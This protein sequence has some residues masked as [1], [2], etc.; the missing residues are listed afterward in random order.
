[1]C[2]TIDERKL[3][4]E[5]IAPQALTFKPENSIRDQHDTYTIYVSYCEA[6]IHSEQVNAFLKLAEQSFCT[7]KAIALLYIKTLATHKTTEL[8]VQSAYRF[9][10]LQQSTHRGLREIQELIIQWHLELQ[11]EDRAT[12]M[13]L[14]ILLQYKT[15]DDYHQLKSL[16]DADERP[17]FFKTIV[18]ESL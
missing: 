6:L 10:E 2:E 3:R 1:L 5:S 12:A 14:K 4:A 18:N 8:A 17:A 13:Q 9:L 15:I 11:Q 7:D 16:V